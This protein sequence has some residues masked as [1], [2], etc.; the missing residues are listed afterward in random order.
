MQRLLCFFLIVMLTGCASKMFEQVSTEDRIENA[1]S[2]VPQMDSRRFR[3]S[4]KEYFE[5]DGNKAFAVDP[6]TGK[7]G[8]SWN[9]K[10]IADA[11]DKAL[12]HCQGDGIILYSNNLL[13]KQNFFDPTDIESTAKNIHVVHKS[14]TVKTSESDFSTDPILSIEAGMHTAM[15]NRMGIDPH[16]NFLVTPS[17]DRTVRL[18]NLKNG[19]LLNVFRVPLGSTSEGGMVQSAAVSPDGVTVAI[20][21]M[22]SSWEKTSS[23][24]VFNVISGERLQKISGLPDV[25]MNM[26][27]SDDGS[28]LAISMYGANGVM[29]FDT[30]DYSTIFKDSSYGNTTMGVDFSSS[31][32]LVSAS[33]DGFI[34]LYGRNFKLL[35]KKKITYGA[36]VVPYQVKFSSD[37]KRIAVGIQNKISISILSSENLATESTLKVVPNAKPHHTSSLFAVSWSND[38]KYLYAGG[39]LAE[40]DDKG[41]WKMYLYRW[42]A[43]SLDKKPRKFLV[44]ENTIV[45][46][47]PYSDSG[48]VYG[49]AMP[50][51]GILDAAGEKIV[52]VSAPV[53]DHKANRSRILLSADAQ[54]VQYFSGFDE[55]T[56]RYFSLIPP[57]ETNPT[58]KLFPPKMANPDITISNWS[59][60][61][62][63]ALNGKTLK[64]IDPSEE[65][66]C[67][68][69]APNGEYF[70]IGTSIKIYAFDKNG[71][72]MWSQWGSGEVWGLNVARGKNQFVASYS[73]GT[74]R[75]HDLENGEELLALFPH[76]DGKR[77]VAWTPEGFFDHSPGGEELIG[78]H[79]N[80]SK[81]QF[82]KFVNVSQIYDLYYRPDLIRKKLIDSNTTD[83]EKELQRIGNIKDILAQGLPPAIEIVSPGNNHNTEDLTT[84][85]T[86]RLFEQGGGGSRLTYSVNGITVVEKDIMLLKGSKVTKDVQ[87]DIRLDS[88]T[89]II[90]VTSYNEFSN[91]ESHPKT[92]TITTPAEKAKIGKLY[93][94]AVGIDAYKNPDMNLS[95]AVSDSGAVIDSIEKIASPQLFNG[96]KEITLFN[97]TATKDGITSAFSKLQKEVHEED[98]FIFYV[99]AHGVTIEDKFYILPWEVE[100]VLTPEA[101]KTTGISTEHLQNLLITIPARK[102]ITLLDTCYSSAF[103][104]DVYRILSQQAALGKL[105]RNT[106]RAILCASSE[107]QEAIE[108]YKGH[109]LFTYVLVEGLNGAAD[110]EGNGDKKISVKEASNYVVRFVPKISKEIWNFKQNPSFTYYGLNFPIGFVP[111]E[112]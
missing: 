8:R 9:Y 10:R 108:G 7:W 106:G 63:P 2:L 85:L 49:T 94:L 35:S 12:S 59:H 54:S 23:L 71:Q 41:S 104:K 15:I 16:G 76:K 22:Q 91:I 29:V 17:D 105:V 36:G 110:K 42:D 43:D 39:R 73:D 64:G 90:K 4:L 46:L 56:S 38:D 57:S 102:S 37:G 111:N 24:V 25:P 60:E 47:L 18:W 62:K 72:M 58:E 99:A 81:E 34:R 52:D 55:N 96:V 5:L 84:T 77:W 3:A 67:Y 89:N 53:V 100:P 30:K 11:W 13:Q 51:W 97:S 93:I 74:I 65:S 33:K 79:L 87:Q 44:G 32:K 82:A 88:G 66:R 92:V 86:V 19:E 107:Q 6:K 1:I 70:L 26:D 48:I 40:K 83:L 112:L 109:G 28:K 98:L 50:S 20:G 95:Y 68:A 78:Y 75:W 69:L 61:L 103:T 101:I 80:S 31:G 21:V 45:S 14:N 27:F